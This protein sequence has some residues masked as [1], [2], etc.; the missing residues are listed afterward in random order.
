MLELLSRDNL[1]ASNKISQYVPKF[2]AHRVQECRDNLQVK[3]NLSDNLPLLVT[4][5]KMNSHTICGSKVG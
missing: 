2:L 5:K 1:R 4:L 3:N